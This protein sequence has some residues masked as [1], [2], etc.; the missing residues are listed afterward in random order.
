MS[1]SWD[2]KKKNHERKNNRRQLCFFHNV[3]FYL[4]HQSK[5]IN[6]RLAHANGWCFYALLE[7]VS[8]PCYGVIP[9]TFA[10][11]RAQDKSVC[12]WPGT[13]LSDIP[14]IETRRQWDQQIICVLLVGREGIVRNC[15]ASLEIVSPLSHTHL[16]LEQRNNSSSS[17]LSN[18]LYA[19]LPSPLFIFL[20]LPLLSRFTITL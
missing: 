2:K 19:P 1:Y 12:A 9:V 7:R 16:L 4:F 10:L 15:V 6:L 13:R 20:F 5:Q 8:H 14:V 3:F 18:T 17:I 11:A